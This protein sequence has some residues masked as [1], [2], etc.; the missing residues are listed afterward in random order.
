MESPAPPWGFGLITDSGVRL[1]LIIV[2]GLIVYK[3]IDKGFDYFWKKG[4]GTEYV[5]VTSCIAKQ[6]NCRTAGEAR[7]KKREAELQIMKKALLILVKYAEGVPES[8]KDN[9]MKGMID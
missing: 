4:P 1:A 5:T 8:E 9:I 2:G 6:D 3:L 7:S